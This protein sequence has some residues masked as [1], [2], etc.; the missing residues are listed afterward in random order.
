MSKAKLIFWVAIAGFFTLVFYQNN[1][2]FMAKN[3]LDINLFF[4]KTRVAEI[5][6]LLFFFCF[7]LTGFLI[8]YFF[9]LYEKFRNSQTLKKL[10]QE[11]LARADTIARLETEND[12]LKSAMTEAHAQK[13]S[14]EAIVPEEHN[15]KEADQEPEA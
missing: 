5:P 14:Q 2:Y 8:A 3:S 9:S 7:F 10:N 4:T 15:R 6:N 11:L 12:S 1:G 13:Q